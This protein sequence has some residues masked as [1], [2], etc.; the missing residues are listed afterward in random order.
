MDSALIERIVYIGIKAV[1]FTGIGIGLIIS[2][3][4]FVHY[5]ATHGWSDEV[6]EPRSWR[7]S[8][9]VM[10]EKWGEEWDKLKKLKERRK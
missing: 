7:K 10:A 9:K 4:V 3:C 2:A 6:R 8:D 5:I 1:I